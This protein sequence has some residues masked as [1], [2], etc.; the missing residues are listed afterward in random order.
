MCAALVV[1]LGFLTSSAYAASVKPCDAGWR[2]FPHTK[3][4]Y[5]LIDEELPWSAAEYRCL[6]QGA[7]HTSIESAAENQF[8]HELSRRSEMWTGAAYFGNSYVNS[9]SKPYGRYTNWKGGITP[10]MTRAR[11]CIK[12]D[13]NGKWFQSCCRKVSLTVCEKPAAYS[14]ESTNNLSG[15]RRFKSRRF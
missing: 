10:P 12:L 4:C 2:Y 15:F 8:V 11:R 3:S 5:K 7:H 9:D 13:R 14:Q 6:F 1:L